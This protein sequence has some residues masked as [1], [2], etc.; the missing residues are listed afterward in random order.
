MNFFSAFQS[1]VFRPLVTLLIPGA[2]GISSWTIALLWKYPALKELI[3]QNHTETAWVLVLIV[4]AVGVVIEDFGARIETAFDSAAN[5]IHTDH[6]DNW[7]AYLRTS[8][9]ADPIGRRYVRS[10]VLR[11]KFELGTVFGSV[12]AAGGLVWL[13]CLGMKGSTF[14]TLI[15]FC[16]I[17][18]GWE[19][20]EAKATHGALANCRRELLKEI[21]VVKAV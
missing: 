3:T 12:L 21:R 20:F 7:Y 6:L 16:F 1:E 5:K 11:L 18:A 10:L 15:L 2:L 14:V 4:T 9:V 8:F 19:C 13:A 17:L